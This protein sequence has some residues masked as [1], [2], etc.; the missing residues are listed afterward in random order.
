METNRSFLTELEGL[1]PLPQ[2]APAPT[3]GK[4]VGIPE[5]S[6]KLEPVYSRTARW[7]Q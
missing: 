2:G 4:P 7:S 6:E 3:N 1:Q 5:A